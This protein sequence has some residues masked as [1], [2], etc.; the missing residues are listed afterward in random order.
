MAVA[1]V[2]AGVLAGLVALEAAG[3]AQRTSAGV[4][5]AAMQIAAL[6]PKKEKKETGNA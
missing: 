6:L 5:D 4:Q 3:H 2:A 1:R